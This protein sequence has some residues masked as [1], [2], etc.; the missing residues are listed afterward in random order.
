MHQRTC[1]Q[2]FSK[3]AHNTDLINQTFI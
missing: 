2:E 3:L 1:K